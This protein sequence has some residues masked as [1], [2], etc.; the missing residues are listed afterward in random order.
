MICP[1]CRNE[2]EMAYSILSHAFV[3]L[4]SGCGFEVEVDQPQAL[5]I[6]EPLGELACA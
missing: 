2:N 4:Q 3:C 5:Q 1:A 6:L